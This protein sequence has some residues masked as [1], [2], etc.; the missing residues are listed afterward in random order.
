MMHACM[1]PFTTMTRL[2]TLLAACLVLLAG[3]ATKTPRGPVGSFTVKV[4]PFFGNNVRVRIEAYERVNG[5]RGP[6]LVSS[7]VTGDGVTG[8]VLPLGKVYGVSA[9]ADVDRD[10]KKGPDDP[11]A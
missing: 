11:A 10:G 6:V 1:T 7:R 5:N 3:C 4:V 8:F 9:W 2:P